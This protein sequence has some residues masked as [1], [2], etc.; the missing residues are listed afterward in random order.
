MRKLLGDPVEMDRE[1]DLSGV[2]RRTPA[3]AFM[4]VP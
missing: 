2:S 4:S 1:R 3:L